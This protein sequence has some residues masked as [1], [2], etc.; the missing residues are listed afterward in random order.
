MIATPHYLASAAGLDLLRRGGSAV[1][2]AIGACAVLCVAYPHMTGLGGDGFWLIH[3]PAHGPRG[4]NASGPA[5]ALASAELLRNRGFPTAVPQRGALAAL[6][7]PGAVDGWRAAHERY[8]RLEWPAL[9]DHA[10]R[11]ARQGVPVAR[12]LRRW[13]VAE[14]ATLGA[15]ADLRR[16]YL[17]RGTAPAVGD[18]IMHP[19]LAD[20]LESVARRGARG[21]FY[22]GDVAHRMCAALAAAGSPLRA[23]DLAVFQAEWVEPLA[24]TYRDFAAY[25]LP[26]NTQG[27]TALHV[28]DLLEGFD[29]AAWGDGTADYYH[30]MAEI[31]KLAFADR[32]AWLGDPRFVELPLS[33]LTSKEYAGERRERIAADRALTT[34][35]VGPGV[36]PPAPATR[37]DDSGGDTCYLCAVDDQGLAVSVIQSIYHAFGAGIVAGGTGVVLH[38]RGTA[39]RLEGG[40]PNGLA[41]GKR[42]AHTLIP[43]MLLRGNQP[44]LLYGSMGGDGQPQTQAAMVT[45]MVD[46]DYPVQQVIDA[47]RWVMGR[48]WG[49]PS[50]DLSI[51][52]RVPGGVLRELKRR[53]QPVRRLSAWD[54][55]V[56]HA[57]AIRI[58]GERGVLEGGAD[59]RGDGAALGY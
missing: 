45:R 2:A 24:T 43:A 59:P 52:S 51:E 4:L 1:D 34:E 58:D 37:S 39:F 48:T 21:G 10:I 19:D 23:E 38:N 44:F 18:P 20:T 30:H 54:E 22:E 7:V 33:R 57:Q 36:A 6:T 28:L 15:S 27:F 31:M 32:D 25:Q 5:A 47:P 29:V 50:G 42:P 3:D 40:H 46:F 16:V 8:G 56:G 13:I 26:P 35:S 55:T 49:A 9:F 41:P 14:S 11:H 17:P 12:S 53:G